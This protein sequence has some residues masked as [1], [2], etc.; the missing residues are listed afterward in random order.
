MTFRA[1]PRAV[2]G[3]S[4]W[5]STRDR[6]SGPNKLSPGSLGLARGQIGAKSGPKGLKWKARGPRGPQ[7]QRPRPRAGGAGFGF[8]DVDKSQYSNYYNLLD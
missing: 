3:A 8:A 6:S 2:P 5:N 7:G 1:V 4:P